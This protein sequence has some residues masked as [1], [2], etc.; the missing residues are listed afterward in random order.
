MPREQHAPTCAHSTVSSD[1]AKLL[2][3]G[4]K[5][6]IAWAKEIE[7]ENARPFDE[8]T[9]ENAIYA[10]SSIVR[11]I[12]RYRATRWESLRV[13]ARAVSWC[14]SGEVYTGPNGTTDEKL[15]ESILQDLLSIQSAE[16]PL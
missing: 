15:V 13:K 1:D 14:W 9:F 4:E 6:D 7:V 8:V 10:S 11:E 2:A 3:L 12:R 5:L 16:W